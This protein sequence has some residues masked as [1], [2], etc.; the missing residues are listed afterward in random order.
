MYSI[1]MTVQLILQ[2]VMK[3]SLRLLWAMLIISIV[4]CQPQEEKKQTQS[5]VPPK[6]TPLTFLVHP[7]DTPSRLMTRFQPLCDYLEQQIGLPVKLELASSYIDQIKRISNGSVDLAYIGPTPFLRAQDH[8]LNG[9]EQQLTP[10]AAE[11]TNGKASYHSVIVVSSNSDIN[12]VSQ[13]NDHSFAFGAPHSFSSHYTSRTMLADAGL[14]LNDLRDFAY[15]GSH[16]RVALAVLHGDF[17]A[18][19]LRQSVAEKYA[20]R[21][22]GLKIIKTSPPLPPHLIVARPGLNEKLLKRIHNALLNPSTEF[23]K[24]SSAL[25]DGIYFVTP[26]LTLFSTARKVIRAIEAPT[27]VPEQW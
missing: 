18:G 11:A 25:G 4:A 26:D 10:L 16:E 24:A 12:S 19:G 17:D 23:E 1:P 7:Y 3:I 6:G 22:P 8:Y 20:Q 14:G 9:K 27:P 13:L 2:A 5:K 21:V 15:L